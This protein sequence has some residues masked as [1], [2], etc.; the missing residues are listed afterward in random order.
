MTYLILGLV[1]FLGVHSISIIGSGARD[2]LVARMG[3]G[4]WRGLYSLL[5]LAGLLMLIHG[6][7]LTRAHPQ[8]LYVP[9]PWTRHAAAL[10]MLAVFPLLFAA[11]L[12]GRIK[13][14]LQHPMLLAVTLWSGAHLLANGTLADVLLFGGFLLWA[15]A[16]L[17]SFKFRSA[18]PLRTAP[19]RPLNDG[20]AIALGLLVYLTMVLWLHA[21]LIGVAPLP[22]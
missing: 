8:F 16:D 2:R 6:H 5:A 1:L 21:R 10:L 3:A 22:L 13:A 9:A 12:P 11:Y 19:A 4:A 20:I 7:G 14:A 17:I 18:R 15:L